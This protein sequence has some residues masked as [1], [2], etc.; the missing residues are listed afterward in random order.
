MLRLPH[1]ERF[2]TGR[3]LKHDRGYTAGL[4]VESWRQVAACARWPHNDGVPRYRSP[5]PDLFGLPLADFHSL[6]LQYASLRGVYTL[7]D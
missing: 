2:M 1:T 3:V 5:S 4:A 7:H 6:L